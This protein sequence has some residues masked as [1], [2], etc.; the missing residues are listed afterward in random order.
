VVPSLVETGWK[1]RYGRLYLSWLP[2]ERLALNTGIY[3]EALH[4]TDIAAD[5]DGFT[6]IQLLQLP[7]ELRYFDP[8]GLLGLVRATVVREQ[9]QFF[10][11]NTGDVNPGKGTFATVDMGIGWRYP[12][13]PLIASFEVQNLLDANF[14][15]QSIDPLYPGILPRRT[16]LARLTF[17]L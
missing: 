12:G 16:F 6:T 11:V 4:R 9:G 8:N 13:R 7:V 14:H 10:D 15:F 2:N 5:L 17:R 1:E 3:Y